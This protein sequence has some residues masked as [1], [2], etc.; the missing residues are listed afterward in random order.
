MVLKYRASKGQASRAPWV[1]WPLRARARCAALCT[2]LAALTTVFTTACSTA[3]YPVNP[4]LARV[5]PDAGYRA[6]RV[7]ASE[8][9]DTLFMHLSLSG[10]GVRAAAFGFG[11]LEALRDTA[12]VW[13][14]R[15][16]RLIDQ[17]DILTAVSGGSI[18]AASY[19]LRGVDGLPDFEARFL[20]A[21]MQQDLESAA[22]TPHS[23]WRLQSPRFGRSDLLAEH[24]DERLFDGATF[25]DLSRRPR[26]PFVIIYASDM[27]NGSRFD[28]VQDQ[29][30]ALCSDLDGVPLARAVAASSAVPM[31]LSP[32]TLWNHS[33]GS[34]GCGDPPPRPYLHLLDGGLSDNVGARGP[35]EYVGRLGSVIEGARA[36]GY[37]GV[38]HAVFIVVNAE[39]SVRAA[40]DHSPDVPGPLRTALALADIPINRNS[41][42]T[43]AHQRAMLTAWEAEVRAAH[44]RGDFEVYAQGAHFHLV[45][46][47]LSDVP[48][49]ALRERLLSIPTTLQLPATDV[50]ALRR[51]GAAALGRSSAFRRL[52]NDLSNP[53]AS[54]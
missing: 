44:E 4:K 8:P 21:S 20:N 9:G 25:A 32:I 33:G 47:N 51:E 7:L 53:A 35:T 49:L 45:E 38:R 15:R 24:L 26:K 22:L 37:R 12:I 13:E 10:G 41:T 16:Q 29:F 2:L 17:L 40:G 6:S 31:L 48:D 14:G 52:L 3:H 18:L 11:V 43:L 23:L 36:H 19:A 1:P 50:E 39:T 27:H 30:D 28:F 54:R 5:D 42:L 46:V 34:S